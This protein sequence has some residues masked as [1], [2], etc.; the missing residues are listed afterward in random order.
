MARRC[1]PTRVVIFRHPQCRYQ[2]ITCPQSPPLPILNSRSL[3]DSGRRKRCGTETQTTTTPWRSPSTAKGVL[4]GQGE[5]CHS[6]DRGANPHRQ[7]A[8]G[9]IPQADQEETERQVLVLSWKIPHDPLSCSTPPP[10]PATGCGWS[11][12]W[13]GRD[14][15]GVHVLLSN[16]RWERRLVKFLPEAI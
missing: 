15:G 14:P 13:E 4:S 16:P 7:L 2:A 12:V 9:R 1:L 8:V 11:G 5:E 10:R 3:S 6:A